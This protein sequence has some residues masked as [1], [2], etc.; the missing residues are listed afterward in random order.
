MI[1]KIILSIIIFS[2]SMIFFGV[3]DSTEAK[4]KSP[5]FVMDKTQKYTYNFY[6]YSK[7]KKKET[8]SYTMSYMKK[9][10]ITIQGGS[11]KKSTV[12]FKIGKQKN[13]IT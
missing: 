11:T 5:S 4:K 12:I 10:K 6:S 2:M 1:K 3:M 13:I 7:G 9:I 8:L